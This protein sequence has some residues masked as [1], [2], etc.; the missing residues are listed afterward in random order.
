MRLILLLL[1]IWLNACVGIEPFNGTSC[2][3]DNGKHAATANYYNPDTK[4]S[5]TYELEVY[6]L[7]CKIIRINF[8]NGGWLDKDHIQPVE[9]D[10][11]CNAMLKDDRD[12]IWKVHLQ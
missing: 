12:R 3:F 7:N 5:A 9:I 8:S 4:Y 11:N 1:I 10:R 6:V 2:K